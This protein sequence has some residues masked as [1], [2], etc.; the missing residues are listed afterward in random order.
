MNDSEFNEY[1]EVIEKKSIRYSNSGIVFVIVI[2]TILSLLVSFFVEKSEIF[3]DDDGK[4]SYI[5]EVFSEAI[6]NSLYDESMNDMYYVNQITKNSM[7]YIV[8]GYKVDN[9]EKTEEFKNRYPNEI[10]IRNLDG[11]IE[12]RINRDDYE[13]YKE[14]YPE[15]E[16]TNNLSDEIEEPKYKVSYLSNIGDFNEDIDPKD[17][18]F[19]DSKSSVYGVKGYYENGKVYIT[20]EEIPDKKYD[21]LTKDFKK[22]LNSSYRNI[23]DKYYG[24]K[25][26]SFMYSID[27]H[28]KGFNNYISGV[29]VERV[30]MPSKAIGL[31]VSIGFLVAFAMISNYKK[32]KGVSFADGIKR[33]PVEIVMIFT[34]LWFVPIAIIS[35][36]RDIYAM[37]SVYTIYIL[38]FISSFFA[39]IAVY[40]YVLGLKAIYNEGTSAFVFSN[41]IIIRLFKSVVN[42]F[43]KF[44]KNTSSYLQESIDLSKDS[45]NKLKL[46]CAGLIVLGTLGSVMVVSYGLRFIVWI[47]WMVLVFIVYNL[48]KKYMIDLENVTKK[49]KS[50]AEG[51]YDIKIDEDTTYFKGVAHSFNTISDNLS[52]AVDEAVKSERLKSELITNVSHDLKTPLTSIINYSDLIVKE[53]TTEEEKNEYAEVIYE[54]SIKLKHLIEDLFEVSKASS[55][56]IELDLDD[57]D[58]RAIL[59][60]I[61]GEWEDKFED[62]HLQIVQ[63]LP[64]EP[65]ILSLDGNRTSRVLDNLFSNIYKYA[66]PGT[67]VYVDL[68]KN[69]NEIILLMKNISNYSLNISASEL[70]DRFKR[71][72]ESRNTEGSGLGLSIATSLIEAQ[73][74][75]FSLEIDGDLFK[76]EIKF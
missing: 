74:G 62:R 2:L 31:M 46:F 4:Y 52:T 47:I 23:N 51:N 32:L 43:K 35:D 26:L 75:K 48:A 9:F 45:L 12:T 8:K 66:M 55:G 21:N 34:G 54:K 69:K 30:V 49:S 3:N 38:Q 37:L 71:G 41:S 22:T 53:N 7:K 14:D 15:N 16:Y 36:S 39:L 18:E 29:Y 33:F 70:V 19:E 11:Q 1:D 40:Y 24:I 63:T 27:F 17:Y 65:I 67:R 57:I 76:T 5:S 60:Q 64:E 44:A 25:K 56:N 73:G 72:D 58:L 50:I 6:N 10:V 13:L 42:W 61:A 68:E 28:S 59:M 20:S